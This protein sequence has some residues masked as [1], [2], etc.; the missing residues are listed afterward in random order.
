MLYP[1]FEDLTRPAFK[2][3][4]VFQQHE[5]VASAWTVSGV[6]RFRFKDNEAVHK[7]NSIYDTVEDSV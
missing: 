5:D 2:Q 6:V 4:M 7:V 1:F 3:L